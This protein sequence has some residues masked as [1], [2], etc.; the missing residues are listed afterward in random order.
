MEKYAIHTMSIQTVEMDYE[1]GGITLFDTLE[2]AIEEKNN[3]ISDLQKDFGVEKICGTTKE[4]NECI[5]IVLY[6]D[7]YFYVI[8]IE[9]I[10]I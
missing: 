3:I 4:N 6:F 5:E 7:D 2:E 10:S 8:K 1:L 9:K